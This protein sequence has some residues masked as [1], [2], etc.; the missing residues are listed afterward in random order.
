MVQSS[1][2][3]AGADVADRSAQARAQ[4]EGI[5]FRRVEPLD[6]SLEGVFGYLVGGLKTSAICLL[7]IRQLI[8]LWRLAV[9]AVLAVLAA[10]PIT[11]TV[12]MLRLD[13][14]PGFEF[15]NE[16]LSD[17]RRC[18]YSSHGTGHR[19]VYPS[20]TRSRVARCRTFYLWPVPR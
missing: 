1:S 10:M 18:D 7:T 5:R 19:G 13:R 14:T 16:I 17:V 9:L 4:R 2:S 12:I 15:E 20:Q 6:D 3:Q 11:I 8:G